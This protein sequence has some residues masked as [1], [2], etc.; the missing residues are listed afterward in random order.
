M[1]SHWKSS[2]ESIQAAGDNQIKLGNQLVAQITTLLESFRATSVEKEQFNNLREDKIRLEEQLK[3]SENVVQEIRDSRTSTDTRES[4]LRNITDSLLNELKTLRNQPLAVHKPR[5]QVDERDMISTWQMKYTTISQKLTDSEERRNRREKEIRQGKED[6]KKLSGQLERVRAERDIAVQA[7]SEAEDRQ[8][9]SQSEISKLQQVQ[10]LKQSLKGFA[11]TQQEATKVA[12]L[13]E[14]LRQEHAKVLNLQQEIAPLEGIAQQVPGLKL[15]LSEQQQV[16]ESLE[17]RIKEAETSYVRIEKM[18]QNALRSAEEISALKDELHTAEESASSVAEQKEDFYKTTKEAEELRKKLADL[19]PLVD[20]FS[21][22]QEEAQGHLDEVTRLQQELSNAKNSID[23]LQGLRDTNRRSSAE[24]VSLQKLVS[25]ADSELKRLQSVKDV[26]D[27][28]DQEIVTLN[29]RLREAEDNLNHFQALEEA[30]SDK[31][32]HILTLNRELHATKDTLKNLES[33]QNANGRKDEEIAS[34]KQKLRATESILDDVQ[35]VKEE[36]QRKEVELSALKDK[37]AKMEETSQRPSQTHG[38]SQR[39]TAIQDGMTIDDTNFPTE[40]A[41]TEASSRD[42]AHQLKPQAN[43]NN[44]LAHAQELQIAITERVHIDSQGKPSLTS[45]QIFDT[46]ESSHSA[47]VTGPEILRTQET[48]FIP[49][50]QPVADSPYKGFPI[51]HPFFGSVSSPLT[52]VSSLV[53]PSDEVHIQSVYFGLEKVVDGSASTFTKVPAN[54]RPSPRLPVRS[55]KDLPSSRPPSSS[56]GDTMLLEAEEELRNL[57]QRGVTAIQES[58]TQ[59]SGP[60]SGSSSL[61]RPLGGKSGGICHSGIQKPSSK[62]A[63][64]KSKRDPGVS[65]KHPSPRRLRRKSQRRPEV[66]MPLGERASSNQNIPIS[67]LGGMLPGKYLPNL[68]AKR[69]LEDE[70]MSIPSSQDGSKRMKRNLSALEAK[71]PKNQKGPYLLGQVTPATGTGRLTHPS[72]PTGGR[73][74]NIVGINAPAPGTGQHTNKK[75]R[76]N[77]KTDRYSAQFVKGTT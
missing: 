45:S 35:A 57:G 49:E 27:R 25:V 19:Q 6:V 64:T 44:S 70:E 12:Q 13:T 5:P 36:S 22:L 56:Y 71:T 21:A 51:D 67:P 77:S 8:S 38:A 62:T 40:V 1:S 34:L 76:K 18:E 65:P 48:T 75:P 4:H 72:K 60:R 30:I 63:K 53:E 20:R 55:Q 47:P 3:S 52:H 58:A 16:I 11:E 9:T 61:E 26:S 46:T 17:S 31:D 41:V 23:Q 73:K 69:R 42:P 59:R 39:M 10:E 66:I 7:L 74:G 50:S 14:E 2:D 37:L 29:E 43:W 33:A 24:I 68:A 54:L 28:K 15:Q 32:E